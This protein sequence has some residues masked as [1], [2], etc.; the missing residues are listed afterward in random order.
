M[1]LT[2]T[3]PVS[4]MPSR[5]CLP[6]IAKHCNGMVPRKNPILNERKHRHVSTLEHPPCSPLILFQFFVRSSIWNLSNFGHSAT[7]VVPCRTIVNRKKNIRTAGRRE[8]RNLK[9]SCHLHTNSFMMNFLEVV[10][11]FQINYLVTSNFCSC[12]N[13]KYINIYSSKTTFAP[14]PFYSH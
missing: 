2:H 3:P 14:S 5:G 4:K 1:L 8:G 11:L 10:E 13:V 12:K 7:W 6:I 9:L